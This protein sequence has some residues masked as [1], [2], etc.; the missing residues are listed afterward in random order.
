MVVC[1]PVIIDQ[2]LKQNSHC[3]NLR[4]KQTAASAV[5]LVGDGQT[6]TDPVCYTQRTTKTQ[7]SLLDL[8]QWIHTKLYTLIH[9]GGADVGPWRWYRS[10]GWA[11]DIWAEHLIH[12]MI[13]KQKSKLQLDN[14]SVESSLLDLPLFT[15]RCPH[16]T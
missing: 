2:H 8:H 16:N 13:R 10:G 3:H 7:A 1:S 9:T 5:K 11:S 12:L 14:K 15:T 6:K 4:T